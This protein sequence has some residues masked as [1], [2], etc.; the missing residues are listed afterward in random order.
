MSQKISKPHIFGHEQLEFTKVLYS[1][2]EMNIQCGS[3]FHID[4]TKLPC[5]HLEQ[6][7]CISQS[8]HNSLCC[9][10]FQLQIQVPTIGYHQFQS[11]EV[12]Y[13]ET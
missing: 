5:G 12:S 1:V 8:Q 13:V 9:T 11:K 10:K 2:S 6:H 7:H 3:T 4:H